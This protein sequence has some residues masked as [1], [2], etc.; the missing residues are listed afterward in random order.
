MPEPVKGISSSATPL[1]LF[2]RGQ[3]AGLPLTVGETYQGQ[4]VRLLEAGGG[5]FR[6]EISL[7]GHTLLLNSDREY[8]VGTLLELIAIPEEGGVRL[9]VKN[10]LAPPGSEEKEPAGSTP[11]IAQAEDSRE[12]EVTRRMREAG[13]ELPVG[14]V[15]GLLGEI[16]RHSLPLEPTLRAAVELLRRG[17]PLGPGLLRGGAAAESSLLLSDPADPVTQLVREIKA[18]LPPGSEREQIVADLLRGAGLT[19]RAAEEMADH[20][21]L[22]RSPVRP[23][24]L[25]AALARLVENLLA[26]DSLLGSIRETVRE[27]RQLDPRG[28]LPARHEARLQELLEKRD[29]V[30]ARSNFR[31]LTASARKQ[32]LEILGDLQREIIEKHPEIVRLR[33][34]LREVHQ[35]AEAASYLQ[36]LEWSSLERDMPLEVAALWASNSERYP[37]R[38]IIRDLR[39][40]GESGLGFRIETESR[41]LGP[42]HINGRLEGGDGSKP[43]GELSLEFAAERV[44]TR[45]AVGARLSELLAT[46]EEQGYRPTARVSKLSPRRARQ[47]EEAPESRRLDVKG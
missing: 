20:P 12:G 24:L 27:L 41:Y 8:P 3:G 44:A 26:G 47:R 29:E 42:I 21:S 5:G 2:A 16:D 9:K 28:E 31:D 13:V 23:V 35:R 1:P 45:H 6:Y 34:L 18:L 39:K 43:S 17:L 10:V 33:P 15:R 46:L 32:A 40:R 22:I 38:F 37:S 19:G 36:L 30:G 14:R 4:I 25:E 11:P 7:L